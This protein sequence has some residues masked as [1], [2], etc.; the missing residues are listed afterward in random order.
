ML[1]PNCKGNLSASPNGSREN[2]KYLMRACLEEATVVAGPSKLLYNPASNGQNCILDDQMSLK[3]LLHFHCPCI[4]DF[5]YVPWP[6]SPD[7]TDVIQWT[8]AV[9]RKKAELNARW[10]FAKQNCR[11]NFLG[12]LVKLRQLWF[13][14]HLQRNYTI[15]TGMPMEPGGDSP[16]N[17]TQNKKTRECFGALIPTTAQQ[18]LLVGEESP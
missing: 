13:W 4:P 9:A 14:P 6:K 2:D 11:S 10:Q 3:S 7:F 12:Q 15:P 8:L 1:A 16:R 18:A 5:F 17:R